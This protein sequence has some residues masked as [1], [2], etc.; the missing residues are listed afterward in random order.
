MK[1]QNTL[2][3]HL[4][5]LIFQFT[6]KSTWSC[7]VKNKSRGEVKKHIGTVEIS[8]LKKK[9]YFELSKNRRSHIAY[10][11]TQ[12]RFLFTIFKDQVYQSG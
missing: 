12:K 1:L 10:I 11:R 4:R 8:T 7:L 6:Q 5:L 2:T 9:I 3:S